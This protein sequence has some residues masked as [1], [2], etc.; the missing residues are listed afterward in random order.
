MESDIFVYN[1]LTD[2]EKLL[3]AENYIK[4]LKQEIIKINLEKGILKSEIDELKY[5]LKSE[6]PTADKL[7][8]YKAQIKS[9]RAKCKKFENLY[10]QVNNQFLIFKMNL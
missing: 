9:T 2:F 4:E 10:E 7:H 5:R 3:F 1:N 8:K 6:N